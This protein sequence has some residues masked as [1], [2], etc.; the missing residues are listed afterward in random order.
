M[1]EAVRDGRIAD[2]VNDMITAREEIFRAGRH[3]PRLRQRRPGR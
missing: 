2:V 1:N 3:D